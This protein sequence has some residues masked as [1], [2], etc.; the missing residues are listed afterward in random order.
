MESTCSR[1][2][3]S[4][5]AEPCPS[6][7]QPRKGGFNSFHALQSGPEESAGG[8]YTDALPAVSATKPEEAWVAFPRMAGQQPAVQP[9][10]CDAPIRVRP[11]QV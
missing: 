6:G 2:A 7:D 11:W 9:C 8:R 5:I 4:L 1:T 10:A 3:A